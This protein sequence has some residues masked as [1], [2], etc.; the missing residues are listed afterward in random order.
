MISSLKVSSGCRRTWCLWCLNAVCQRSWRKIWVRT[1]SIY[2]VCQMPLR[3]EQRSVPAF[4]WTDSKLVSRQWQPDTVLTRRDHADIIKAVWC[5]RG[6]SQRPHRIH[7]LI[8]PCIFP[9]PPHLHSYY[10]RWGGSW[11]CRIYQINAYLLRWVSL[12]SLAI[13]ATLTLEHS[14]IDLMVAD[15]FYLG[16]GALDGSPNKLLPDLLLY[17]GLKSCWWRYWSTCWLRPFAV[18]IMR[19]GQCY[20]C[21]V[22]CPSDK[23]SRAWACVSGADFDPECRQFVAR[24]WRHIPCGLPCAFDFWCITLPY[25]PMLDSMRNTIPDK[26]FP[27]SACQ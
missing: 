25:L 22:A 23:I 27:G 14:Q 3:K 1:V 26:C 21:Q 16:M 20:H 8:S 24:H 5:H 2:M 15:W 7:P 17:S 6:Q 10:G 4:F 13:V 19:K 12:L 18:L 11:L 9:N